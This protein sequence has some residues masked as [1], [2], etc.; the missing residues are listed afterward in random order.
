MALDL[1]RCAVAGAQDDPLWPRVYPAPFRSA[2]TPFQRDRERIVQARAFRRLAGKTQ[3]F[4]SRASD[5]F[6]SRLTHTMEVA[7]IAR[8][9]AATLGLDEDLAETL[10]LVHDIG[11]PPFGHAGERALD[12]CLP[13]HRRRFYHNVH[14][15]RIVEHFE[16][17]YAAHRGLSLTLGVREGIIKHSRDYSVEHHPEL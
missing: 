15:M 13:P 5:H 8:T 4:T 12:R 1:H 11:H 17:R 3:V 16:Q 14:T 9:V 2:R 6:R 10:A 7:Q